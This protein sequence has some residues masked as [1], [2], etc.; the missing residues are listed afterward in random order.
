MDEKNKFW[1]GVMTG[2][3]IT[4][5]A[6][7]VTVGTS[8]GIY[9]F[10]RRAIDNQSRIQAEQGNSTGKPA[11]DAEVLDVDRIGQKLRQLDTIVNQL[12]LF[13]DQTDAAQKEAGI[14]KGFLYGLNDPYAAYYT[15]EER[16]SFMDSTTGSYSGIGAMVSQNRETGLSTIIRVYQDSPAEAAGVLPGDIIYEVDG[17]NVTDLDLS[18]LVNNYVKGEEGTD[19]KITMYREKTNEYKDFVITRRK[20]DVRT[21]ET[22]MLDEETGYISVMEFDVVTMDQFKTGIETLTE[23]GMKRMIV[24]L[25]NNPGGELD[26]V[27]SMVDYIIPD[28]KT[29]VSISD[30]NGTQSVKSSGD[31]HSLDIPIVVLVNG[32]SASASEVFTGALKDYK[33]ATIVGTNTFGKGIVQT[34]LPLSDGSAVKLTTAHYYTPNG[35]DIHGKGIAP[36]IT[37]E[38]NEDAAKMAVI[39]KEQDNQLQEAI[40]VVKELNK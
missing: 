38:L 16:Q 20:L 11:G 1:K 37:V 25:R 40:K 8:L 22:E 39:P 19:V 23:Q 14:Y 6:C 10:G 29:I 15:S 30:K 4:A 7:L 18:L 3:L 24:D 32:N 12:Y 31:G 17:T 5:F 33:A 13:D 2:V 28:E 36:D 26:T 9:M 27:V 35:T 34:V 21:V